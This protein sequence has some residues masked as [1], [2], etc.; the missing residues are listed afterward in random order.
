MPPQIGEASRLL[1][2]TVGETAPIPCTAIGIPPPYIRWLKDGRSLEPSHKYNITS[3]GTLV[4][5]DL[6]V[7]ETLL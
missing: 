4:I 3:Y 7:R 1:T 5:R 2:Y 6:T